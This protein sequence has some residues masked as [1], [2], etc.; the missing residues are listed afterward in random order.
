MK[1]ALI[2][3]VHANVDGGGNLRAFVY[4]DGTNLLTDTILPTP[5]EVNASAGI[6]R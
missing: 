4:E 6:S 2:A 3:D 1:I 5:A